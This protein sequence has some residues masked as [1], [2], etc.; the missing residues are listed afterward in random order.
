ML[1]LAIMTNE[2][3]VVDS[4]ILTYCSAFQFLMASLAQKPQSEHNSKLQFMHCN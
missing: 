3:H 4:Q 2:Q 1:F